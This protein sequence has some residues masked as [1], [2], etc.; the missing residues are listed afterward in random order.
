MLT[1]FQIL[2]YLL[3]SNNVFLFGI[4]IKNYIYLDNFKWRRHLKCFK[5]ANHCVEMVRTHRGLVLHAENR[6]L[7]IAWNIWTLNPAD[8]RRL[9]VKQSGWTSSTWFN[10]VSLFIKPV[11][12][13]RNRKDGK[14]LNWSEKDRKLNLDLFKSTIN[15][16]AKKQNINNKLMFCSYR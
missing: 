10:H 7:W 1:P 11:S 6:I 12:R 4:H 9:S 8:V 5:N 13:C 14:T 16:L 15:C 2:W 3:R